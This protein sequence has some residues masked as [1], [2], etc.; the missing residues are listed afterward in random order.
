MKYLFSLSLV[1]F[2]VGLTA[3][4]KWSVGLVGGV[5]L[6]GIDYNGH[7]NIAS[8]NTNLV[9]ADYNFLPQLRFGVNLEYVLGEKWVLKSFLLIGVIN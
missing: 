7:P 1:F 6:A 8:P 3:Q 2:F 9:I 5:D 4:S